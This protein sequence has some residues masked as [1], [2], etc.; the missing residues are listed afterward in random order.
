MQ[1][2]D[3]V[4][5]NG[6][7][8]TR[9]LA[10]PC[11]QRVNRC[12]DPGSPGYDL[13]I[14]TGISS[15]TIPPTP[16]DHKPDASSEPLTTLRGASVEVDPRR[17]ARI[18]VALC[19]TALAVVAVGFFIA[20][21][22]KN[23]EITGLRQQG[24]PVEV[25]VTKCFGLLGGSGSNGVGNRCVG[26]FVLD[27]R[28]YQTTIPGN[29]LWGPGTTLRFVTIKGDAGLLATAHQVQSEHAS[30][31]VFVLPAILLIVL[32][33]LVVVIIVRRRKGPGTVSSVSTPLGTGLHG[34]QPLPG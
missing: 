34:R 22:D 32:A 25:T 10:A 8:P 20:G 4:R 28:T 3:F 23:A 15:S 12:G 26:T 27:G 16:G 17:A 19:L 31:R 14:A 21:V 1:G 6:V 11:Y 13:P 24:I 33:A 30:W 18:A 29:A 9:E 7:L 5:I 2:E